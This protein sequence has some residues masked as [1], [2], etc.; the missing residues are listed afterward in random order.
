[1]MNEDGS[2]GFS[3]VVDRR[4]LGRRQTGHLAGTNVEER[5][6]HRALD[7]VAV[8]LAVTEVRELVGA[9]V[10]ERVEPAVGSSDETDGRSLDDDLFHR[11]GEEVRGG[12]DTDGHQPG[13]LSRDGSK[14][15]G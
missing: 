5:E 14:R 7:L 8:E 6:V 15:T 4:R 3:H 1:E 12:S 10:T 2:I 11:V 9:L 13:P